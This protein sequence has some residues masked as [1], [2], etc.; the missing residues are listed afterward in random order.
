MSAKNAVACIASGQRIFV[1]GGAATPHVLLNALYEER[2]RLKDVELIHLHLMGDVPHTRKDF[3]KSFKASN[4]FVGPNV[5]RVLDYDRIDYLP[6]FLSEMPQLFRQKKRAIEN[7]LHTGSRCRCGDNARACPLRSHRVRQRRSLW[8]DIVRKS[9][10]LDWHRP[11]G[12]SRKV[13]QRVA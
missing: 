8:K 9:Q 11:P 1:Q 3:T 2:G 13:S 6:C 4:L 5:R 12:R 7:R 10:S